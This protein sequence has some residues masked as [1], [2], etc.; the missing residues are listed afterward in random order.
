MNRRELLRNAAMGAAAAGVGQ[1]TAPP[2]SLHAPITSGYMHPSDALDLKIGTPPSD[3]YSQIPQEIIE[4]VYELEQ[5]RPY[6]DVITMGFHD[7]FET[8]RSVKKAVKERWRL[9]EMKQRE[10]TRQA[11]DEQIYDILLK[12]G[13]DESLIHIERKATQKLKAW[14]LRSLGGAR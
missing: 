6:I 1:N 8:L 5:S 10:R 12:A 2:L 14:M 13:I 4:Q 9:D 7:H 11:I 3:P